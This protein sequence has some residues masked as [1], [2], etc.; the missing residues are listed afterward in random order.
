MRDK[1]SVS[2]PADVA[3]DHSDAVSKM[4]IEIDQGD[5]ETGRQNNADGALTGSAGADLSYFA[6]NSAPHFNPS[7]LP[8]ARS[9]I[10][11]RKRFSRVSG[12]FAV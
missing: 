9:R 12:G 11:S 10:D 2:V 7:F 6:A 1:P 5:S 4:P 8:E 3:A